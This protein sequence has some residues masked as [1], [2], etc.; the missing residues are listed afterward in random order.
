MPLLLICRKRRT[1]TLPLLSS[2]QSNRLA[3]KSTPYRKQLH[4][5]WSASNDMAAGPQCK[6]FFRRF[7][8]PAVPRFTVTGNFGP[9][10]RR[11]AFRC[12]YPKA[13]RVEAATSTI[14]TFLETLKK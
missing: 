1:Q 5:C 12:Q 10:G 11:R 9:H 6:K 13:R 4:F 7:P 3:N 2:R 14:V 8:P